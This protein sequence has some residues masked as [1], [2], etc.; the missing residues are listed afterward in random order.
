MLC[1][2]FTADARNCARCDLFE[3]CRRAYLRTLPFVRKSPTCAIKA[4]RR[5]LA[6][7]GAQLCTSVLPRGNFRRFAPQPTLRIVYHSN[8]T[9][10][11][12]TTSSACKFQIGQNPGLF[13]SL[14]I[15]IMDNTQKTVWFDE[16]M[17]DLVS[18]EFR[19]CCFVLYTL[20]DIYICKSSACSKQST[21]TGGKRKRTRTVCKNC[22]KGVHPTCFGEHK[23]V[24]LNEHLNSP[25]LFGLSRDK[26]GDEWIDISSEC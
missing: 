14:A 25:S 3:N 10:R 23:K 16:V 26:A 1:L 5:D 17:V 22:K 19:L 12:H 18:R 2:P 15:S 7:A 9:A 8:G 24:Y 11:Q 6:R 4:K 21:S 13:F 20:F